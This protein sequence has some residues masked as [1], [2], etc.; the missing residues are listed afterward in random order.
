VIHLDELLTTAVVLLGASAVGIAL[1]HRAGFGSVLGLL[2]TGVV[3]GPHTPG[4]VV[5]I[6]QLAAAAE[7]GVVFLLFVIGL[8]L[9]PRRLWAM[10]RALFGLGT[11]QVVITGPALAA[12][13]LAV[14]WPGPA[15]F[16]LGL[17]LAMSSTAFVL[18][19]LTE[20]EKLASEHGRAAF[21]ILLLQDIAVVPLLA[22]VPLLAAGSAD[23][24]VA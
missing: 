4:P 13:G 22:M 5:D 18:Q 2:A 19:L 15:A 3:L 7:L 11:L 9:E 20:R 1:F 6:E 12:I 24:G 14:G 21:A 23:P 16:V 17:G 8:E 10:R